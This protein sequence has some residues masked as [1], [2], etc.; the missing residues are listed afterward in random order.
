MAASGPDP[1]PPQRPGPSHAETIA[2]LPRGTQSMRGELNKGGRAWR[3]RGGRGGG[4]GRR[5]F[6]R[7]WGRR[8]RLTWERHFTVCFPLLFVLVADMLEIL[9]NNAM[10]EG[11]FFAGK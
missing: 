11:T 7:G 8:G 3:C 2:A 6:G 1:D 9:V 10:T 5:R 4:G